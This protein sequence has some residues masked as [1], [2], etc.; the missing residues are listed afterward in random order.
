M[1]R[2]DKLYYPDE[3]YPDDDYCDDEYED[4]GYDYGDT[5]YE[6][7]DSNGYYS[8]GGGS[9][10]S[11]IESF[12]GDVLQYVAEYGGT[13][14]RELKERFSVAGDIA[15][16]I[17]TQLQVSRIIDNRKKDRR[18]PLIMRQDRLECLLESIW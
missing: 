10:G 11:L 17:I 5:E 9:D 18:Y 16:S 14:E 2:N 7:D 12:V 13:S 3:E 4:N 6:D 15:S 8:D 1:G